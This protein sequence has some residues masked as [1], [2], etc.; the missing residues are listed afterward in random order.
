MEAAKEGRRSLRF[1]SKLGV[2][3]YAFH[4]RDVAPE[5]KTP[6]ESV[7]NLKAMVDVLG[8]KQADTGIAAGAPR[9]PS[10]IVAS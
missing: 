7:E 2:L 4:D 10:A 3:Y 9:T 1:I 6:K 5:G 8:Q